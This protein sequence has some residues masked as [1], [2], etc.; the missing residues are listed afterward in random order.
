MSER[1]LIVGG[2]VRAAWFG[3]VNVEHR[4]LV[5][6]M[7]GIVWLPDRFIVNLELVEVHVAGNQQGSIIE[8]ERLSVQ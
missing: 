6:V 5:M 1:L 7:I 4:G 8:K 2:S 3:L